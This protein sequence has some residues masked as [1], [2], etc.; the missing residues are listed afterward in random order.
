MTALAALSTPHP[1]TRYNGAKR[2][3]FAEGI[4]EVMD[5]EKY[6]LISFSDFAGTIIMITVDATPLK[7]NE[8]ENVRH[9]FR[10]EVDRRK[11]LDEWNDKYK[12]RFGTMGENNVD[13]DYSP[14]EDEVPIPGAI[15]TK[16]DILGMTQEQI[17]RRICEE[18]FKY[19]RAHILTICIAADK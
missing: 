3:A 12:E 11:E 18:N 5:R 17:S 8:I 14:R 2:F 15:P 13:D 19:K 16:N 7:S 9:M 1:L 4:N 6:E 10:D